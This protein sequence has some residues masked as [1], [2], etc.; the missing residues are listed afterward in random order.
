MNHQN[1]ESLCDDIRPDF[2][3]SLGNTEAEGQQSRCHNPT[4]GDTEA[5]HTKT[6]KSTCALDSTRLENTSTRR[7]KEKGKK[8]DKRRTRDPSVCSSKHTDRKFTCRPLLV[9]IELKLLSRIPQERGTATSRS[10]LTKRPDAQKI[11]QHKRPVS[12][13]PWF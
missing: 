8:T 3:D 9:K 13:F 10:G 11:S 6:V 5:N 12:K 2:N 1:P 4:H 7:T